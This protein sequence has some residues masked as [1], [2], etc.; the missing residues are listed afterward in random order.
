M[1]EKL[2]KWTTNGNSHIRRLASE[3]TRPRLPWA[4][5]MN[6]LCGDVTINLSLLEKL[7][8]DESPYVRK[9]VGNHLND[10]S[11]MYEQEVL[12]WMENM[13]TIHG[14]KVKWVI[15]HG[16]RSLLKDRNER[17]MEIVRMIGDK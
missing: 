14:R 10:L 11:K 2:H 7:I 3:G 5:H 9:S 1:I 4:K 8:T 16:L 15:K 12:R 17:S 6:V 13:Y